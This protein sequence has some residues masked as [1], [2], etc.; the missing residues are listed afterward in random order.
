MPDIVADRIPQRTLY[1]ER[2]TLR[3]LSEADWPD[4]LRLAGNPAVSR[5]SSAIPHPLPPGAARGWIVESEAERQRG[6]AI[7]FAIVDT[8]AGRFLGGITLRVDRIKRQ[9]DVGFWFGQEHWGKGF[10]TEALARMIAFGFEELALDDIIA[11]A[12]E[13]NL[14]SLRV[15]K[16]AGMI[17]EGLVSQSRCADAHG[18]APVRLARITRAQFHG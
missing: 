18:D 11:L 7:T 13:E 5:W 1:T 16:K 12:L 4:V 3:A 9:G 6:E 15:Q 8:A 17:D 14:G 2:L 10:A